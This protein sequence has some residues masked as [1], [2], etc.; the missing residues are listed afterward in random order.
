MIY[1][2]S[3]NKN[4]TYHGNIINDEQKILERSHCDCDCCQYTYGKEYA[5]EMIVIIKNIAIIA[6]NQIWLVL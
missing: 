4:H 2:N 6:N 3:W 1:K 5:D